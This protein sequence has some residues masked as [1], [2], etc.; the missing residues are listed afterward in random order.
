MSDYYLH[1]KGNIPIEK[2]AKKLAENAWRDG[3][4]GFGDGTKEAYVESHWKNYC[5]QDLQDA[6]EAYEATKTEQ[7]VELWKH[8]RDFINGKTVDEIS[9]SVTKKA[10]AKN[11]KELSVSGIVRL[12]IEELFWMA[13]K[14]TSPVR[15]S[16]EAIPADQ[17]HEDDGAVLWWRLPVDEAPYCGTPLDG[18]MW[19]EDYY[20]HFTRLVI[21]TTDVEDGSGK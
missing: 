16:V 8:L 21:P 14:D 1:S 9:S 10:Y 15:E 12:C 20:T 13:E 7:P 2:A 18:A 19:T 5:H 6:I 11:A 4:K 17:W 3:D